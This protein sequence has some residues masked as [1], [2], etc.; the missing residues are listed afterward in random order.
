MRCF[1][2]LNFI[3]LNIH[4][5][6]LCVTDTQWTNALSPRNSLKK[7]IFGSPV[8]LVQRPSLGVRAVRLVLCCRHAPF[9][10]SDWMSSVKDG[11]LFFPGWMGW[12]YCSRYVEF[13]SGKIGCFF[14]SA[15]FFLYLPASP[16]SN[17][18]SHLH[19]ASRNEAKMFKR[20]VKFKCSRITHTH[21]PCFTVI[22]LFISPGFPS[23]G[24]TASSDP[25]IF[26]AGDGDDEV[27]SSGDY[28]MDGSAPWYLRVQE[29]AHDS[30]IAATRAQI[31][32]D[33]KANQDARASGVSNG[34]LAPP[35]FRY[36]A[37]L[38]QHFPA[39][40]SEHQSSS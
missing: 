32:R 6:S 17:F 3:F 14:L 15:L 40:A 33:A 7:G 12:S 34:E 23:V 36:A 5:Y 31:A 16:L 28:G 22:S 38:L 13:P 4:F 26:A 25:L 30:L 24:I 27:V 8:F 19:P 29:L 11:T 1:S 18:T 10:R 35:L 2:S 9:V 21:S 20:T 39:C 37:I